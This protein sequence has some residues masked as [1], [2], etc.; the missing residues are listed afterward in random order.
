[1]KKT[2]WIILIVTGIVL[3]VCCCFIVLLGGV[4]Y[5]FRQ[6][7]TYLP[8]ISPFTSFLSTTPT[9]TIFEIPRP[10]LNENTTVT[11]HTV[12]NTIVPDRDLASLACAFSNICN[13]PPT[14][15]APASPY[16]AG[17]KTQLWLLNSDSNDYARIDV[18]LEYVTAHA[19]FWVQDGVNFQQSEAQALLDTFE[20]KIYPTDRNFFGSEWTPGVD[21]DPHLYIVYAKDLGGSVAGFY[22][23][24]DEYP[25]QVSQYSNAHESFYI[26]SSQG[27]ADEYTY[28]VLAHEFQHMIHWYQDRNESSFLNEG[29]S[30][31]ASFLNGYDTGGFDWFY[32]THPDMNLT[33]WLGGNG[34]NS[35]HYGGSFLFLTYFLDRFGNSATQALVHDQQNSL[36]SVDDVLHNL[37]I[38]DPLTNQPVTADDFFLDWTLANYVHDPSVGDGRYTYHNYPNS[39]VANAT[40]TISTCPAG[41]LTR[42]VNQYGVDYIKIDC[43]GNFN[44]DFT[45]ATIARLIPADPH[46][47]SYAF[48]SNKSDESDMT[49]TRTFDL[50]NTSSSVTMTY[51][52]WYDLEQDYDY[53]YLE[54]ST[55]GHSWSIL[56]TPSGTLDNPSGNSYGWGYNGQSNGWIQENVDLSAYAGQNVSIRFEYITD[57]AVTGNGLQVD[58]ISIPAI[59]YSEDF[60][61]GEGGW[62]GAG[63][64]RVENILPQTYRLALVTHTGSGSTVDILPVSTDQ[65]WQIPIQIGGTTR[66]QDVTLVVTGTTRFT[67]ETAPYQIT[68]H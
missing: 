64:V 50:T 31:V 22:N 20:S 35:A 53:V 11:L 30:E 18:T 67:L 46:S 43:P 41:P 4:Y 51:W 68:I 12:E 37:N 10:P 55:D 61:S 40:E 32:T 23:T 33:D 47:G 63:F 54:A 9:P 57:A 3:I 14:V 24:G 38:T 60:E 45:G 16:V 65:T 66:V 5:G 48:W 56:Q 52:T 25:P 8:T 36:A 28:G 49:L 59:N 13:V 19:Y 27:L 42:T 58:D 2:T 1:M 6:V 17:D 21:N 29:F 15:R 34:D 44:L 62:H 39:P 7:G 26:D